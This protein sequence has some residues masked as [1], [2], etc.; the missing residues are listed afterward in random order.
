MHKISAVQR[1][2]SDA[3]NH[4]WDG[5]DVIVLIVV[6]ESSLEAVGIEIREAGP[7]QPRQ[8][9]GLF[10]SVTRPESVQRLYLQSDLTPRAVFASLGPQGWKAAKKFCLTPVLKDPGDTVYTLSKTHVCVTACIHCA[11]VSCDTLMYSYRM[12]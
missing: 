12:R 11:G 10:T 7:K 8:D 1:N 5:Q 9:T 6:A 3:I 4:K 2:T